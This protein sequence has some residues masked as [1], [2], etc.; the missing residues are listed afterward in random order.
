V[1]NYLK[2]P[3]SPAGKRFIPFYNFFVMIKLSGGHG[4]GYCL[5][6]FRHKP[7]GRDRHYDR[8]IKIIWKNLASRT[9]SRHFARILFIAKWGFEKKP[10]TW[11]ICYSR[12][13]EK[14]QKL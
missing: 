8:F 5:C 1:E 10:N 11:K 7:F 12:I 2:K 14:H 13:K 9:G 3:A 6:S 4:G